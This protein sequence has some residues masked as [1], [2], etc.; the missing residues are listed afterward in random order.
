MREIRQSGSE[1]GGT[2]TN[3]SLL[4]L[5]KLVVR[6]VQRGRISSFPSRSLVTREQSVLRSGDGADRARRDDSRRLVYTRPISPN[7]CWALPMKTEGAAPARSR[8]TSRSL[9]SGVMKSSSTTSLESW[10][11]R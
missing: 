1:G 10:L 9:S 7:V 3:R 4:P 11:S 6:Q 8:S 2:E 5:L